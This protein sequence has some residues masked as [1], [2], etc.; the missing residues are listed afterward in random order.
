MGNP[1]DL[2]PKNL[3]PRT[4]S[5][6]YDGE[7]WVHPRTQDSS[8]HQDYHIFSRGYLPYKPSFATGKLGGVESKVYLT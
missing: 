4:R 8:H 7:F 2:D 5:M 6:I 1:K 3:R